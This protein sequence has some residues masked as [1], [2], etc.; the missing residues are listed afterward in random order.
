MRWMTS[1]ARLSCSMMSS[2]IS[3][4]S[5]M[6]G[7]APAR[8]RRAAWALLSTAVR[9]WFSSWATAAASSPTPETVFTWAT[10]WR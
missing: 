2:R 5:A 8:M 9:G 4:T 6:H 7:D 1:P 3:R 10:S